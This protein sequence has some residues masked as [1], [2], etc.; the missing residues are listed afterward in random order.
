M[1]HFLLLEVEDTIR[2]SVVNFPD[3][4]ELEDGEDEEREEDEE[5]DHLLGG[6]RQLGDG[7]GAALRTARSPAGWLHHS[8]QKEILL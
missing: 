6:D 4:V 1:F 8:L 3:E 2:G 7:D 5:H